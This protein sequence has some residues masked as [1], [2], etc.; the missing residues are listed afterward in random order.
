MIEPDVCDLPGI[1]ERWGKDPANMVQILRDVQESCGTIPSDTLDQLARLLGVPR[2]RIEATASF[3]H[4]FHAE[5][6]GAYEILFS[7]N[8]IDHMAGKE[9]LKAY[10]CELSLIHI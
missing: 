5:S 9:A 10:L 3:Y 8:I 7:D 2:V 6:H 1:V 4:F